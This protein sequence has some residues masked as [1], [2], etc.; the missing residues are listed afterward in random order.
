LTRST[1]RIR[2][3]EI[4]DPPDPQQQANL[5]RYAIPDPLLRKTRSNATHEMKYKIHTKS[6][7]TDKKAPSHQVLSLEY[8]PYPKTTPRKSRQFYSTQN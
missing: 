3:T 5:Y 2:A 6:K 8:V 1:N 4:S 7:K